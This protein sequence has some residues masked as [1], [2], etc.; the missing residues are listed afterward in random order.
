MFCEVSKTVRY[1][2]FPSLASIPNRRLKRKKVISAIASKYAV[3]VFSFQAKIQSAVKSRVILPFTNG[4]QI[5]AGGR[6]QHHKG[7]WSDGVG[8]WCEKK[9]KKQQHSIIFNKT[10]RWS[11]CA[12]A[13]SEGGTFTSLSTS[14]PRGV[15]HLV[16]CSKFTTLPNLF[17]YVLCRDILLPQAAKSKA[18]P[19]YQFLFF[20]W[21]IPEGKRH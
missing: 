5:R 15:K 18:R 13:R 9:A 11:R 12:A 16:S 19:R 10:S 20:Y 21:N 7:N 3:M 6:I 17:N 4:N 2:N 8:S 14:L 1:K